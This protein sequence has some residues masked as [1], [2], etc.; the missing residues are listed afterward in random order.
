MIRCIPIT[1]KSKQPH[2][3]FNETIFNRHSWFGWVSSFS[4]RHKNECSYVLKYT[5]TL[6]NFFLIS[7]TITHWVWLSAKREKMIGVA[8][9]WLHP[10]RTPTLLQSKLKSVGFWNVTKFGGK[11]LYWVGPHPD[12]ESLKEALIKTAVH[13]DMNFVTDDWSQKLDRISLL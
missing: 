7:W 9:N 5:Q 11:R 2:S 1:W 4:E 8:W 13:I 3:V 12:L 10:T 6:W